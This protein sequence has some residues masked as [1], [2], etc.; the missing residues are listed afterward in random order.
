M[1]SSHQIQPR[2]A[3]YFRDYGN[4]HRTHGNEIC[5]FFGIPMI[6][7]AIVGLLARVTLG[8]EFSPEL[9]LDLGILSALGALA[10][11][12]MLDWRVGAPFGLVLLGNYFLGRAIPAPWLWVLFVVGWIFQLVGH[13]KYEKKSPAFLKN[14]E[15]LLIG[16]LWV[17]S[18]LLR[19]T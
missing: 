8:P 4:F 17:F 2:L 14:I 13:Y 1:A 10:W 19:I 15:H 7:L 18:R 9:R 11:Y 3:A 16:P 5:H 6:L 12:L